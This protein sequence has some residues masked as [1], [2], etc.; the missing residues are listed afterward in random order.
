[1][2]AAYVLRLPGK[3]TSPFAL[4][5]AGGLM[6]DPK[7]FAGASTQ[8]RASLCVGRWRRHQYVQ[9]LIHARRVSR[10]GL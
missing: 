10:L 5:G 1:V 6:F 3:W 4:A 2:S 7:N 8:A 9:A